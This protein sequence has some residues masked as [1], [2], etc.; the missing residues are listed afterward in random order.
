[1]SK[2]AIVAMADRAIHAATNNEL[3]ELNKRKERKA[4]RDKGNWGNARVMNQDVI[5][6]RE[7]DAAEKF[8]KASTKKALTEL[9]K[10]EKRL[11]GLG[12]EL[13]ALPRPPATPRR[14]TPV[15]H[16]SPPPSLLCPIPLPPRRRRM[17]VVL[18]VRVSTQELQQGRWAG[19]HSQEQGSSGEL[20]NRPM[21][22]GQRI[23]KPRR[24]AQ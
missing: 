21:G 15:T 19:Y 23:R 24:A 22:R 12:P 1:M 17:V 20:Q 7:K 11:R 8:D 3:L 18:P 9:A 13:F 14:R 2:A 6:Q 16:R 5:D 10:E 4:S